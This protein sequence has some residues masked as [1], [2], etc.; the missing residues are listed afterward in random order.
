MEEARNYIIEKHPDKLEVFDTCTKLN[1]DTEHYWC[2]IPEGKFAEDLYAEESSPFIGVFKK[3][4]NGYKFAE[5]K[6][7]YPT[8]DELISHVTEL[9][10]T[11]E[12]IKK[13]K[14]QLLAEAYLHEN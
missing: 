7:P 14:W 8:E 1:L 11:P 4:Q 12:D 13:S 2:Y 3:E 9:H 5:Y 6:A 10:V